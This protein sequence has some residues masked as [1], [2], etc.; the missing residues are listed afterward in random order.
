MEKPK[1]I[2]VIYAGLGGHAHVL[3]PLLESSFGTE[4]E[5]YVVFFGVETTLPA[6]IEQCEKLGVSYTCIQKKPRRYLKAF[7][8]FKKILN[9]EKP[10][11]VLVHSSELIVPAVKYARRNAAITAFYIEHENNASKGLSLRL[12]SKYALKKANGVVCLNAMYQKELE[13]DF[14]ATVPIHI[15]PNGVNTETFT[16]TDRT[17]HPPVKIGMASRMIA[18]KDHST[19]L[20]AFKKIT[21]KHPQ[22]ELHIAG[23]G[24]TLVTVQSLVAELNLTR[25]VHF[26]GLLNAAEMLDF[27]A[28]LSLYILAT[29]YETLST[30]LLQAM[31]CELPIITSNIENNAVLIKHGLTGLLY[32][33][34]NS[35]DLEQ[36][37]DFALK[38]REKM[39]E[40]GQAARQTVLKN[41]STTQMAEN[42]TALVRLKNE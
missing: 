2:H 1:I 31:A 17:N 11:S 26:S 36:K 16:P 10:A 22:V 41:Y 25:H 5:N 28:S 40:M 34:Q 21:E 15:I 8:T 14:K 24:P 12:L 42:Y 4:F 35:V 3:F 23:D 29:N 18:G 6:Y 33:D 13:K 39:E 19:L 7:Q 38:N 37:I 30:A 20:Y 9:L 32:E 27:Y